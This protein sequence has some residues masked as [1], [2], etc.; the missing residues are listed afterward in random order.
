MKSFYIKTAILRPGL[1]LFINLL[2][3]PVA[4]ADA[5]TDGEKGIAEYRQGN[6]IAG[7]QLLQKSAQ[8]GYAPA[9]VTLA[10]IMDHA[11]QDKEAFSWYEAAAEQNHAGGLFGLGTMY[12]KGEGIEK[13]PIEAGRL[14]E[15]SA[16]IGHA[17]AML[18][19]ANALEYGQLGFERSNSKSVT[20]Y[21]KAANA[22][23]EVAM[24]RLKNAYLNGELG[25]PIDLEEAAKWDT[26][27]NPKAE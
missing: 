18:A 8:Q 22:S 16:Q 14:I 13:D 2:L 4:L 25:L 11:E 15:Q 24:R 20:W 10:Y 9:Q 7:M 23:E 1:I 26:N 6:M 19:Y 5:K 17:P 3:I 12:A 21:L 27:N